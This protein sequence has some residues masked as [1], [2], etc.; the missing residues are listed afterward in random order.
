MNVLIDIGNTRIKWRCL[1]DSYRERSKGEMAV[2][3]F[4]ESVLR[5]QLSDDRLGKML[6]S[7]VGKQ[8]LADRLNKFAKHYGGEFVLVRSKKIMQGI[9]FV[10]PNVD[11]LGVDRCLA[12]VAATKLV[13]KGF[14]LIDAGSAI[15]A[16][17]VD[18]KGMHLGGYIVPGFR[19][20]ISALGK[21]TEQVR[22]SEAIGD[23]DL[24]KNTIEC[25]N[26]GLVLMVRSLMQ[27]FIDKAGELGFEMIVITGGDAEVLCKDLCMPYIKKEN[28]VLDGL[29]SYLIEMDGGIKRDEM[30][31]V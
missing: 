18:E 5:E 16:D 22:V 21:S 28:L 25:V 4:T 23:S 17:Y 2:S 10:Y 31:I 29:H 11:L 27:G 30:A 26:N 8:E 1:D 12:M 3:E 15:T 20:L 14:L 9:E 7:S 19:M 13:N 24:G 6:V